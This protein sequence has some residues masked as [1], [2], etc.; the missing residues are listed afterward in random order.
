MCGGVLLT[1]ILIQILS[2]QIGFSMF[3]VLW[4]ILMLEYWKRKEKLTAL[5]WG[6]IDF[7]KSE[8]TRPGMLVGVIRVFV[9]F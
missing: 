6:M 4:A 7:E 9:L 1:W 8:V 5:Y 3:I 2:K